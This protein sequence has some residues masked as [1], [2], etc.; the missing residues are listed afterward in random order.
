VNET[1]RTALFVDG[2]AIGTLVVSYATRASAYVGP[3]LCLVKRLLHVRCAGCGLMRSFAAL[4]DGNVS[5]AFRMHAMGPLLFAGLVLTP[6]VDGAFLAL[7]RP[8][9]VTSLLGYRAV[10]L[11][12]AAGVVAAFYGPFQE[13]R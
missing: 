5:E 2:A 6:L 7:R 1:T 8:P 12:V 13:L 10:Q 9:L 11:L 4:W 3:E